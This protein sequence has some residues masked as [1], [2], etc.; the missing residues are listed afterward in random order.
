MAVAFDAFSNSGSATA[1]TSWTHT[2]VGTPRAVIV[3]IPQYNGGTS[4]SDEITTVTYGGVTMTEITGS[5]VLHAATEAVGCHAFFLGSSIPTGAQTVAITSTS[6]DKYEGYCVTLTAAADTVVQDAKTF[7]DNA[8]T[9][10]SVTL[11]LGGNTCFCVVGFCSGFGAV[12]G[13]APLTGWTSRLERDFGTGTGA[14]YTYDTIGSTDVTAGW[15]QTSA[16]DA[17]LAVA[18]TEAGGSPITGTAAITLPVLGV[19][20]SGVEVFTGSGAVVLPVLG[21]AASGAEVFTGSG[22]VVLPDLGV[23]ASGVEVFSGAAG[24]AIALGVAG[25]GTVLVPITGTAAITLALSAS[26]GGAYRRRGG[27]GGPPPGGAERAYREAMARTGRG[28]ALLELLVEGE[29]LVVIPPRLWKRFGVAHPALALAV[30]G[31]GRVYAPEEIRAIRAK[32]RE[33]EA[34]LLPLMFAALLSAMEN[35]R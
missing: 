11:A 23:A 6:T 20:A 14:C 30:S 22:A 32:S 15:T 7:D 10:P 13:I 33:E 8:A 9:A 18:V 4:I 17:G 26:A 5:P 3:L 24:A 19:S 2:P 1:S 29:G 21:V 12:S 31:K 16:T 35:D 34:D 28:R 25:A 27:G